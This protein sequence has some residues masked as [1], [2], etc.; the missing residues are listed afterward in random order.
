M[1]RRRWG[2]SRGAGLRSAV[3]L[4]AAA[5]GFA[6]TTE[7]HADEPAPVVAYSIGPGGLHIKASGGE[8]DMP[9]PDC[10]PKAITRDG[11]RVYVACG[12]SGVLLLDAT[13][14][15]SP[16]VSSRIPTDGE[17]VGLHTVN[18]K[19]WVEIAQIEAR[20][21]DALARAMRPVEAPEGARAT[22]P[23]GAPAPAPAPAPSTETRPSLLSPP[24]QAGIWE[25]QVD[26][27]LFLPIGNIGFGA[28]NSASLG[29]RMDLPIA[30][31]ADLSPLGVGF[32][33]QGT[34]GAAGGHG[35]VALDTHLF[36]AGLGLGAATLN[37]PKG[38]DSTSISFAQ[39]ARI[40]A[41]D[42]LALFL[43]NSIVVDR[44]KFDLGALTIAGQAPLSQ[45]WWLLLRGGGGPI[46][47]AFG[48]LGVRYLVSGDLGPGSLFLVGTAGG[49]S[50][51]KTRACPP[52]SGTCRRLSASYAGPSIGVGLEWRF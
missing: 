52:Q 6:S 49:T 29:Y 30:I 38:A 50:I 51:F 22:L 5:L 28:L 16:T 45:R 2:P 47:F 23:A 42:G 37:E 31:Y 35:I 32:G 10:D 7:V 34:I 33:K 48:D 41:R 46:G 11:A 18:G 12:A 26:T 4:V 15:Q 27:H 17:A 13:N 3:A 20:P 44:D 36:E 14:P 24:R 25:L 9:L 39:H 1:V 19:T 40:G 43:R 21:V 8:H